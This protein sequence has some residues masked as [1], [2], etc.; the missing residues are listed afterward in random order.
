MPK[1]N[2]MSIDKPDVGLIKLLLKSLIRQIIICEIPLVKP[3]GRMMQLAFDP[4]FTK[5]NINDY[6]K[7][8]KKS[9]GSEKLIDKEK[10]I[11]QYFML[12]KC[13]FFRKRALNSSFTIRNL[14]AL[15]PFE[16][17][18]AVF[19]PCISGYSIIEFFIKELIKNF[20]RATKYELRIGQPSKSQAEFFYVMGHVTPQLFL[21][22]DIMYS[23]LSQN[24]ND[25]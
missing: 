23:F 17:L 21:L 24:T 1:L 7:L 5:F 12:G 19:A 8:S 13:V 4:D 15:A 18:Y 11:L 10:P 14:V 6:V 25:N 16:I 9:R 20:R 22:E 2:T 3:R